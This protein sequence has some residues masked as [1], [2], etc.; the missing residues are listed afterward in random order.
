LTITGLQQAHTIIMYD[1]NGKQILTQ[2]VSGNAKVLD[3][4]K[5]TP[6]FYQLIII[7]KDQGRTN[8]RIIKQ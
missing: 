1:M 5:L 8:L 2:R 6:G 3:M 4:Q 7:D